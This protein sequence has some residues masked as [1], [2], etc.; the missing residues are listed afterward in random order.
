MDGYS[1]VKLAV[2]IGGL[3]SFLFGAARIITRKIAQNWFIGSMIESIFRVRTN[4][5]RKDQTFISKVIKDKLAPLKSKMT[6]N[7]KEFDH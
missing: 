5:S 3:S 4:R 7:P 1:L 6:L 2:E